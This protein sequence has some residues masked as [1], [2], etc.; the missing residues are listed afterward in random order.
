MDPFGIE[1]IGVNVETGQKVLL[2]LVL[3]GVVWLLRRGAQTLAHRLLRRRDDWTRFWVRQVLNIAFTVLLILVIFS[4]WFDDPGRLA[5]AI[6]LFTAGLAFAL[7]KVI[8]SIAGYFVI[9][10]GNNF[11]VGD[12]ITMGGVR[13]DV[14]GLG[15]IQTTI[16][17]MGQPPAV[18]GADPAVWVRSRQYTGRVVTVSNDTIF[19]TPV[20]NYTRHFPYIWEEL[21]V[22]VSYASDRAAAEKILR[23][24]ALA[25]TRDVI[26]PGGRSLEAMRRRYAVQPTST[27][28]RVYYRLTNDWLE[29]TVRFL[30]EARGVRDIKD[31]M[32]RDI[33]T[34]F[35]EAGIALAS[36]SFEVLGVP[37]S[38]LLERLNDRGSGEE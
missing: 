7:Q 38:L 36:P 28:P 5:T 31:A 3:G 25:H 22:G 8:T 15:F 32:S 10:R 35:D 21:S 16:M 12:R 17:E 20:Y 23:S 24:V 26:E 1:L 18:Q 37:S 30:V 34:R 27:E 11:A 19:D 29:L 9:L 4:I 6:G 14:I 33:L 2:T 13:G